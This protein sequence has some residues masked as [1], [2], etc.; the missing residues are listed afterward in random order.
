MINKIIKDWVGEEKHHL[1]LPVG[2]AGDYI[3]V[4]AISSLISRI[5]QIKERIVGEIEKLKP[6]ER[7]VAM[8]GEYEAKDYEDKMFARAVLDQV[9]NTFKSVKQ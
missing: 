8:F 3:T 6:D 1:K 5:P 7:K 2:D 4:V 9:I